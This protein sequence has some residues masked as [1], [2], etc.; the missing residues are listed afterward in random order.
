MI[1]QL[2]FCGLTKTMEVPEQV[3]GLVEID[4]IPATLLPLFEI[5]DGVKSE[6]V[7]KI[8]L[9]FTYGGIQNNQGYMIYNLTH[10]DKIN[11]E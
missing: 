6:L 8:R 3:A 11:R 4:W 9:I 5:S 10:I 7:E 1:I 2:E